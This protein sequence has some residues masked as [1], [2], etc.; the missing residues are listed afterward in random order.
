MVRQAHH[1]MADNPA[2]P[3][4]EKPKSKYT[5]WEIAGGCLIQR[6]GGLEV[7]VKYAETYIQIGE[8]ADV[9]LYVYPEIVNAIAVWFAER[10]LTSR[11]TREKDIEE[12]CSMIARALNG[13]FKPHWER[14]VKQIAPPEVEALARLM[15]SSTRGDAVIL[16]NPLLYTEDYA[17]VRRD[18][19]K[20]HAC[21]LFAK[22]R[23]R[24]AELW[25]DQRLEA[26]KEW[27]AS[28]CPAKPYKAL[29]KTLDKLPQA[30]S[31]KQIT[32]LQVMKLEKPITNRL[33]LIFALSV[34][35]HHNW[36]LHEHTVLS[37]DAVL[38]AGAAAMIGHVLTSQS[39]T[40]KISRV[41]NFILD[42]PEPY[43][44]DLVGLANRSQDWHRQM[45]ADD[46]ARLRQENEYERDS[47]ADA[48][49]LPVPPV[50]LGFLEGYGITF[51]KT[52]GEVYVEGAKMHHCVGSYASKAAAGRCYLFH[53]DHADCAATVEVSP[54]GEALQAYGPHNSRNAACDFGSRFL[55]EAF[56]NESRIGN[57]QI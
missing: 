57:E 43:G 56:W 15:W 4:P 50:D 1:I 16:H 29:N 20:Y 17:H 8:D 48:Y 37:A 39:K 33:H 41:A 23:D 34:A 35:E 32:R 55:E 49:A 42:Y 9:G 26:V 7:E 19:L 28:L 3:A 2:A 46:R 36:G 53:V 24:I 13:R 27:R 12:A 47:L 10:L 18:L 11:R 52:A 31:W 54:T 22:S 25:P 40:E 6:E 45:A 51:L 30:V 5:L 38:V 21:R 14:M 44:G